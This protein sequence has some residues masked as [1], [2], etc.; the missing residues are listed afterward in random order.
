[1]NKIFATVIIFGF[2][3]IGVSL[4]GPDPLHLVIGNL[5]AEI[6]KLERENKELKNRIMILEEANERML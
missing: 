1:M 3:M 6:K 4:A 2:F 5:R